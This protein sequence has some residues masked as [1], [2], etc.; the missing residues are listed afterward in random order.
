M[1]KRGFKRRLAK[2]T[3]LTES[4]VGKI[5]DAIAMVILDAMI[6]E[7]RVTWTGLGSFYSKLVK[8]RSVRPPGQPMSVRIPAHL[9]ARFRP[10][11]ALKDALHKASQSPAILARIAEVI[12]EKELITSQ[13]VDKAVT[14]EH[15]KVANALVSDA[16]S[17][18]AE[19]VGVKPPR[20]VQPP[21]IEVIEEEEEAAAPAEPAPEPAVAEAVEPAAEP[22]LEAEPA[23]EQLEEEAGEEAA[24][25]AEAAAPEEAPA[26][27]PAA[28][29]EEAGEEPASE[30]AAVAEAEPEEISPEEAA[31]FFA[32]AAAR[33]SFRR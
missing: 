1:T 3:G 10:S 19:V 23:A 24:V 21:E 11:K 29:V 18:E 15:E 22:G 5:L 7:D 9:Q 4:Q 27:E 33:N 13:D 17:H 25:E 8:P 16:F 20:I 28:A 12:G 14:D 30:A 6:R 31:R 2:L 32:A 26:E